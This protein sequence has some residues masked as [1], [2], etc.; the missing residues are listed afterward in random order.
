MVETYK[1]SF[2][3]TAPAH[4]ALVVKHENI[5]KTNLSSLRQ[6]VS[7]GSVVTEQLCTQLR[8]YLPNGDINPAYG[9]SENAGFISVN[10]PPK[11]RSVG[12]LNDNTEIKVIDDDGNPCGP[13]EQGE[14]HV[15]TPYKFI[16]YY[17]NEEATQ[18][19]LD[20]KDWIKTGDIGYFDD[21]NYLYIV[22]RKKDLL[23]YRGY[24]LTSSEI[25]GVL[26]EHP[27]V[28]QVCVVGIP[29]LVCVDL[30]AAVIVRNDNMQLTGEEVHA[31]TKGQS[32]H[33]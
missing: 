27:A 26:I 18:N 22:D 1:C 16:G 17:G 4:L 24:Q 20:T 28:K 10:R 19:A 2:V 9:L 33:R 32:I 15:N 23:K 5:S 12:L 31:F 3:F 25:E 30:P 13:N 29:D 21:D 8:S 11:P 6:F 14:I 7:G